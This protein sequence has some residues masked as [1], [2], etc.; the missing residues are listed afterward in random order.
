MHKLQCACGKTYRINDD[1]YPFRCPCGKQYSAEADVIA[2]GATKARVR[3]TYLQKAANF[4]RESAAHVATGARLVDD[5]TRAWRLSQCESCELFDAVKRNC[6]HPRCGCSMKKE[7]AVIDALGWASKRCPIGR[8][9]NPPPRWITTADLIAESIKLAATLPQDLAGVVGVPRSGMI[10][11]SAIATHLHLP[12][13]TLRDSIEPVGNGWRLSDSPGMRG[14]GPLLVVDDTAMAGNSC[15]RVREAW[16]QIG[17]GRKMI[18][19]A[20][21]STPASEHKNGPMP[22]VY[23]QL[24]NPPHFLEWNFFNSGYAR[25]TAFDFDGIFTED[26]TNRPQYLPRKAPVALVVTGRLEKDRAAS[27]AWL[28]QHQVV[29]HKMIMYQGTAEDRD[30]PGELP[31]YKAQHFVES[32]LDWFVESDPEQAKQI[33]VIAKKPVICPAAKTVYT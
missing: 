17:G 25:R 30:A 28:Q 6:T 11:A 27:E 10:P 8:W 26:G 12:L 15:G 20:I 21:Y 16:P 2:A 4:A 19:A 5:T 9:D 32:G 1:E 22:D 14:D 7:R 31:R 23:G 13:F 24:L 29:V 33:A 18:Y 3:P